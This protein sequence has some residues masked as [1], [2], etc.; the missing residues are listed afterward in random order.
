QASATITN[1]Q[2]QISTYWTQTTADAI[3]S[4][5]ATISS[6]AA[7]TGRIRDAVD[8]LKTAILKYIQHSTKRVEYD[9]PP[10]FISNVN[11]TFKIDESIISKEEA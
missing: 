9:L 4:R 8:R 5:T 1:R 3:N 10:K 6:S 11:L 7:N 2:V